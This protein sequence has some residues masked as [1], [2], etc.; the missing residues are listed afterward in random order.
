MR[1]A[2]QGIQALE[3]FFQIELQLPGNLSHL[4]I[5]ETHFKEMANKACRNDVIKG[6]MTLT[7]GDVEAIYKMCL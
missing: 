2:K 4:N 6:L 7:P 5:D 3:D 1:C